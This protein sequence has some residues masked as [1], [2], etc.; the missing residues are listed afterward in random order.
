M[1]LELKHLLAYLPYNLKVQYTGIVNGAE[2]KAQQ[3]D[4]E[5]DGTPFD[6]KEPEYGLKIGEVKEVK[7]FKKYW[8]AYAGTNGRALKA[9]Y[10]GLD[11]KP[12]LRPLSDLHKKI[13]GLIPANYLYRQ[14]DVTDLQFNGHCADPKYGYEVYCFLF[15]HHFDVFDLIDAGLAIDINELNK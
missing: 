15:Q 13:G 2:L 4:F 12:I 14:Y 6:W 8:K 11:F 1:K 10:N 3:K 9:F 5:K 7:V